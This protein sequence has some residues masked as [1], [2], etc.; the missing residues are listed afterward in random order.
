MFAPFFFMKTTLYDEIR[1]HGGKSAP[2]LVKH[3]RA[4]GIT[5]WDEL[6]RANLY[7]LRDELRESVSPNSAKFY[8]AAIRAIIA[9]FEDEIRLPK[10]WRAAFQAKA[11]KPVK[12]FL[13]PKEI[14][15]F[16]SVK[17]RNG[18]ERYVQAAFLCG[19]WTGARVSDILEFTELN[20]RDGMLT[21]VSKK[22]GTRATIP[23]KPCLRDYVAVVQDYGGEV[24]LM[25]YNRIVRE[26]ARRAG[27]SSPVKI[28]RAGRSVVAKKWQSLSS[29]SARVSFCTNL[30]AA[31]C[32]L[33]DVS[34]LAGHSSPNMTA[35]YV[36]DYEV[37]LPAKARAYFS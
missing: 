18:R 24:C 13:S 27:I 10:D 29:H 3:L 17:P 1:R 35:R 26:I 33:S 37:N 32:S 22:T 8:L 6:T 4:A 30:A 31:G 5:N 21:Y 20:I 34:K 2:C 19:C 36:C 9:R 14:D 28:Y 23:A 25:T 12:T 7:A 15:S 16:A 11:E